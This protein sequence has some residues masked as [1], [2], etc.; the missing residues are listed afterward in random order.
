T[1]HTRD[2]TNGVCAAGV[3]DEEQGSTGGGVERRCTTHHRRRSR[4]ASNLCLHLGGSQGSPPSFYSSEQLRLESRPASGGS[5]VPRGV[6][7]GCARGIQARSGARSQAHLRSSITGGRCGL[8]GSAGHPGPQERPHHD[9][10]QRSGDRQS[11]C[12]GESDSRLTRNSRENRSKVGSVMCKSLKRVGGKGGT[13]TLDPGIMSAV[14][15]P[16]ELPFHEGARI[17]LIRAPGCQT[18]NPK[19]MTPLCPAPTDHLSH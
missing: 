6:G 15:Y 11:R 4:S 5:P 18:L 12:G 19:C 16:A 3:G 7:A 10:L 14:L 1:G 9:P 8:G 13:R 2:Q 17:V